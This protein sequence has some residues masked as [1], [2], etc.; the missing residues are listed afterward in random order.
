M[1]DQYKNISVTAQR[2]ARYIALRKATKKLRRSLN[3]GLY[4]QAAEQRM[5]QLEVELAAIVR[6]LSGQS[7]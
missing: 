6:E 4:D 3:G 5:V 1:S 7:K 2:L